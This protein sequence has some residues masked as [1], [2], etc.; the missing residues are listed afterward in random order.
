M[1]LIVNQQT[2]RSAYGTVGAIN[3]GQNFDR[4]WFIKLNRND[5]IKF[6]NRNPD[7]LKV[8]ETNELFFKLQYMAIV[9]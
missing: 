9:V 2:K 1:D 6:Q 3:W 8:D 7:T 5:K 4:Q